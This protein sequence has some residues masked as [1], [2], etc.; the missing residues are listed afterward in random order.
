MRHYRLSPSGTPSARSSLWL[1]RHIVNRGAPPEIWGILGISDSERE[2]MLA[3][4]ERYG[5][6]WQPGEVVSEEGEE[7]ESAGEEGAAGS[8]EGRENLVPSGEGRESAAAA[9]GSA[10]DVPILQRFGATYDREVEQVEEDREEPLV[11]PRVR[12]EM[13]PPVVRN[14]DESSLSDTDSDSDF[15][16]LASYVSCVP[17]IMLLFFGNRV[18]GRVNKPAEKE[19]DL[20]RYS[21]SNVGNVV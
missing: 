15:R 1:G 3:L 13:I 7:R 6:R 16:N 21:L 14:L 4:V 20:W 18:Q 19:T 9:G 10:G 12:Q 11:I 17:W 5:L 2:R 8:G